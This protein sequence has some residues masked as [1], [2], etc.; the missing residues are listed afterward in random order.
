MHYSVFIAHLK[1][2]KHN[3][4]G[5]IL[6]VVKN[7]KSLSVLFQKTWDGE[8]NIYN[9]RQLSL[10]YSV[11]VTESAGPVCYSLYTERLRGLSLDDISTV[12]LWAACEVASHSPFSLQ[13]MWLI[14]S[15]K[16]KQGK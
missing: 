4:R 16:N 10:G 14:I 6:S 13:V 2:H 8:N 9:Y 3:Y 1:W 7:P 12:C 15:S 5:Y 11:S